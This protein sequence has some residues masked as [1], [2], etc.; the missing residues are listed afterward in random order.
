MK[1]I[2]YLIALLVLLAP[3]LWAQDQAPAAGQYQL[4]TPFEGDV[5]F[6]YRWN[7]TRGNPM[8]GEY[9]YQHS[10]GAG[11]AVIEYDPL[12]NRFLFETYVYN[13][14]D[15][16]GELDYS[17][18]D[19]LML[20]LT[21]RSLFHNLDHYTIGQSVPGG[22]TVT[23]FDPQAQYGA[24]TAMNRGQVRF[25][26]PDFPFHIYLEA[27]NQERHGTIQQRF[28]N[29]FTAG[30]KMS[31]SRNV[32]WET[33]EAKATINSH[34]S[35]VEVEF[36]HAAKKFQ[37][38]GDKVMTDTGGAKTYAHNLVPTLESATDTLKVHTSHTGRFSGALTLSKVDR[39]NND[40]GAK[41]D[42]TNGAL[43]FSW[44]PTKDV[45]VAVKY[46]HYAVDAENPD[47]VSALITMTT[48]TN[49]RK[50]IDYQKDIL[51]GLVRWRAT[52]DLIMRF[53][54]GY[55]NLSRD[56]SKGDPAGGWSLDDKVTRTTVRLG[57]NYRLTNRILLRGDISHMSAAVPADSKDMTYPETSDQGRL[58]L[59]WTPKPWFNMLLSGATVREARSD[60]SSPFAD[61][62][63]SERNRVL[64]SFT[65]L[66]GKST[67]IT[68]SYSFF[69]NK[70][71][72]P[73]AYQYNN[74]ITTDTIAETGVPYADTAHVAAL[75]LSY[76]MSDALVCTADVGKSWSRG[77]WQSS[78]AVP[79]SDGIAD[80][81]SLHLVETVAGADLAVRVT[82]NLG[83]D[84]RYHI[85][86]KDDK[87]DDTQD[88][89]NQIALAT[90]TFKW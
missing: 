9:E 77:N 74:G 67:A 34:L 39:K 38:T 32:D 1:K 57:A 36:S 86:R 83:Y 44:I 24:S 60:L 48:A 55:E 66:V 45:T 68:P 2:I 20:N 40:S 81:S 49:V 11:S 22:M 27:R 87:L 63:T 79:G 72:G 6:G 88:G 5:A 90:L 52:K 33:E 15:Y 28:M 41:S 69:Q 14:K 70:W 19:I 84:L 7:M 30:D 51:S 8:A 26:A 25:K 89:T 61:E 76:T 42:L 18:K 59:T 10:S 85:R 3:P 46:R 71:T 65:F 23:D 73:V 56:L 37:D 13:N 16:F 62:W 64:G 17:Y 35:W 4:G 75:A 82:K 58:A 50:A 47:T 54:L 31:R 53:E 78:G 80:L 12:P 21:S 29:S 43:D